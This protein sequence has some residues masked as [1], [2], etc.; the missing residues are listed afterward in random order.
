M[1][2]R[3]AKKEDIARLLELLSQVLEIHAK[4]RPDLFMSG[5]TKYGKEQLDGM[6]ND[7]AKPI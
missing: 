5:T 7:D 2:I 6:I 3:R 1:E 4:L